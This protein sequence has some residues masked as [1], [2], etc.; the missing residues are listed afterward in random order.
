MHQSAKAAQVLKRQCFWQE[1]CQDVESCL[2]CEGKD[3]EQ[4]EV[5]EST[6]MIGTLA[7]LT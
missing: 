1:E 7:R 3:T 5:C 4:A 2:G 6:L